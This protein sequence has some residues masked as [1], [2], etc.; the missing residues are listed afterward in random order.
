MQNTAGEQPPERGSRV[1]GHPRERRELF[2]RLVRAGRRTYYLD[3]K[4]N[5]RK[6]LYLVISE[7]RRSLEGSHERTNVMIFEEDI[8]KFREA[9]RD[10]A[11]FIISSRAPSRARRAESR[12]GQA[13]SAG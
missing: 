7:S 11:R 1:E 12:G 10:V 6:E 9:F 5:A 8:P 3:V 4:V 13:K 2:S